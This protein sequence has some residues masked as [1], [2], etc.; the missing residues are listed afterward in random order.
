MV[1]IPGASVLG[2]IRIDDAGQRAFLT[3][4][5]NGTVTSASLSG[6]PVTNIVT[7]LSNP[8]GLAIDHA[9][10]K[11]YVGTI[12]EILRINLDGTGLERDIVGHGNVFQVW[13][14]A[15]PH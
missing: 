6:G 13:G 2:N 12:G 11:L 15:I 1:D 10:G 8:S 9:N 14:L 3:D 4:Y 7:G 5:N